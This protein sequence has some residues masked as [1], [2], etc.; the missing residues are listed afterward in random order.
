M[1]TSGGLTIC[2]TRHTMSTG[3]VSKRER[4]RSALLVALQEILLEGSM[5]S[6]SVPQVIQRA[7][8]S[9]GTFYNYFESLEAAFD[10]VGALLLAEHSRLVDEITFGVT[11]PIK[12]FALTTRQTLSLT[13]SGDGYG[14]LLFDRGLPVDRFLGGLYI[15]MHK[16]VTEGIEGG[17]FRVPDIDVAL[18]LSAGGVLGAALDLHRGRLAPAAIELVTER[19]L[20]GLG[21]QARTAEKAAHAPVKMLRPKRLP[22]AIVEPLPKD[23]G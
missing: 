10:G 20:C 13:A 4:T 12:V 6:V 15:R 3:P 16:D 21:V 19:L 1:E 23:A 11:D 14:T 18:T 9:Q 2:Q 7:G 5:G 22:L 17:R 8:V